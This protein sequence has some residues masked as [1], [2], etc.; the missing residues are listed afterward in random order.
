M[1]CRNCGRHCQGAVLCCDPSRKRF[2][3]PRSSCLTLRQRR[4]Y[5]DINVQHRIGAGGLSGEQKGGQVTRP[6][7]LPRP[8]PIAPLPS[9]RQLVP[10]RRLRLG[11]AVWLRLGLCAAFA[12]NADLGQPLQPA[13]EE[14]VLVAQQLHARGGE[15]HADDRRVEDHRN[16]DGWRACSLVWPLSS[17]I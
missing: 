11:L 6:A 10:E 3:R 13:W 1:P 8:H 5:C 17:S 12:L 7:P 16:G 4:S 9:M 14:P 15:D 2:P